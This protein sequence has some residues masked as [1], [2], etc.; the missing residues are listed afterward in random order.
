MSNFLTYS[1]EGGEY[2]LQPLGYAALAVLIILLLLLGSSFTGSSKTKPVHTKQLV[3]CSIAIAL[4][5]VASYIK[6]ADLPFGGSVTMFS[7]F[8]ISM[9]GYLYGPKMGIMAGI[10]FGILQLIADPY[11]L[12]PIQAILEY[13]IA[14]GCLGLSGFLYH[15]KHGLVKGYLLGV[16]GRYLCHVAS[17]Y[18]FFRAYVPEGMNPFA[19]TFGYN[20]TYIVPEVIATLIVIFLPPMAKAIKN[21]KQMST[22]Q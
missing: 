14:F 20:A 13:P 16:T 2:L 5:F 17:G 22:Q 18:L 8:F 12:T 3:F 21:I 7:M 6:F 15:S 9:I 11:I 4:A 1:T 10:S 19:Y